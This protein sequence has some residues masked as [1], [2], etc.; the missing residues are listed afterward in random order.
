MW[1][2][3]VGMQS[4]SQRERGNGRELVQRLIGVVRERTINFTDFRLVVFVRSYTRVGIG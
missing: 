3:E 2:R 1:V 4:K